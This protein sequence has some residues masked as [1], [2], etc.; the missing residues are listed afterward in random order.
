MPNDFVR[1]MVVVGEY[2]LR[3]MRENPNPDGW[4]PQELELKFEV[5]YCRVRL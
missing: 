4:R 2:V 5:R 1:A 3:E